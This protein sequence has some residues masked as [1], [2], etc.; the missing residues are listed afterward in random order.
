MTPSP[1]KRRLPAFVE[2]D[3]R[4]ALRCASLETASFGASDEEDRRIKDAIRL[5]LG[6]WITAPIKR[7]LEWSEGK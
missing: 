1:R 2:A 6:S 7:T 3:L 5:W 4:G